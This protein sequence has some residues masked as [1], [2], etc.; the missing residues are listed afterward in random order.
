[1]RRRNLLRQDQLDGSGQSAGRSRLARQRRIFEQQSPALGLFRGKKF[2]GLDQIG[3]AFVPAPHM[4]RQDPDRLAG[5]YSPQHLPQRSNRLR[6]NPIVEF[7]STAAGGSRRSRWVYFDYL[8]SHLPP[9]FAMPT[10]RLGNWTS[11]LEACYRE[12]SKSDNY[13]VILL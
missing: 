9:P 10:I 6:G 1:M 2:A 13:R 8:F 4:R 12:A 5:S 11:T 7:L 3:S